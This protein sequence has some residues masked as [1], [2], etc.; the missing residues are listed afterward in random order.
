[1]RRLH[2]FLA[3]VLAAALSVTMLAGCGGGSKGGSA[4]TGGVDENG[5]TTDNITLT[6]WHYEDEDMINTLLKSSWKNIPTLRWNAKSS[7]T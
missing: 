1:M 6:Y 4:S 7:A 5:V 3:P 2:K